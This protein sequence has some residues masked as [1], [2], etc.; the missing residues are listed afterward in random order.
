MKVIS[1]QVL[2]AFVALVQL[3]SALPYA[4]PGAVMEDE[5]SVEVVTVVVTMPA[6]PAST[7]LHLEHHR[8]GV[9]HHR[10]M[11]QS[12]SEAVAYSP[13]PSSV[14][15]SSVETSSAVAAATTSVENTTPANTFSS[16]ESTST[17]LIPSSSSAAAEATSTT[18]A[19]SSS[20][21]ISKPSPT[22]VSTN[23]GGGNPFTA[24]GIKA[25]LSGFGNIATTY[26]DGFNALAVCLSSLVPFESRVWSQG[27][28]SSVTLLQK[29][30]LRPLSI[31]RMPSILFPRLA[32]LTLTFSNQEYIGWYSDYTPTTPDVGNV[33]GIPMV[34]ETLY[35][36]TNLLSSCDR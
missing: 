19:P 35:L 13:A 33:T 14:A 20:A 22:Y 6:E 27:H 24:N 18:D 4:Q 29:D 31:T 11:T 23:T 1:S 32:K 30:A 12:S 16:S 25:G 26:E 34:S 9:H 17:V 3:A 8:T 7:R 21:S 10:T 2:M 28:V 15:A 5:C 36:T